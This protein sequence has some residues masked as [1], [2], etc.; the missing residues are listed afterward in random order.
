MK[1]VIIGLALLLGA[2]V[3][4]QAAADATPQASPTR[5]AMTPIADHHIHLLSPA[6]AAWKTPPQLPE[7][8]LPEELARV[9]RMRNERRDDQRALE[10]IYTADALYHRG[11]G[12][13]WALGNKAAA[14]WVKW[15][16]SDFPYRIVP[17]AFNRNGSSAQIAGYFFE[18]TDFSDAMRNGSGAQ[19]AVPEKE[20]D[21]RFGTSLL[22]MRREADGRWRIAAETYIFE[23]PTYQQPITAADKIKQ[24]DALGTRFGTI[25]SNAYYFDSAQPEPVRDPLP[26]IR[27]END[28]T[29]EQAAQYPDRLVAF[30]SVNPVKAYALAELERCAAS[31]KF[32]GLKLHFNAAQVQ[33]HDPREV[34][35]VR[36][37]MAA[38]NR[39]R[40]PMLIHVRP[41]NRYGRA[42]AEIFLHTLV[43]AAPDVPIQVAHFWG[44][45]SYAGEALKRY[46]DAVSSRDPVTRNLYFDVSAVLT[47]PRKPE[48]MQEIVARMRQIGIGRLLW[49]SDGPPDE[50]WQG[51]GK[52]V[53]LTDEELR[54]IA[55]NVAPYL[56]DKV[57][58]PR[59]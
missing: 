2:P 14:G 17:V 59:K 58:A 20:L 4:A 1:K 33:F 23:Q 51:F 55:S 47:R 10:E 21:Q 22:S 48:E 32:R 16:I 44:G 6:A 56:R 53:P 28:W 24:M 36:A 37:V 31:G 49:G 26:K 46:A 42:E 9:V 19:V 40:M 43:A 11:G 18:G 54:T 13:G 57:S 38:A 35:N 39:H 8:V 30:C 25:I 34:A 27:A 15:T 3:Q 29:A 7:I 12:P 52:N 50:S 41:G 5:P 45:E